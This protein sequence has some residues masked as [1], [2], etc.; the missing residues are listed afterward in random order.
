MG[1]GGRRR[2]GELL[3]DRTSL[4]S[5]QLARALR[6]QAELGQR[7]G[8]ILLGRGDIAESDLASVLAEQFDLPQ[9]TEEDFAAAVALDGQV[10]VDFMQ[11]AECVPLSLTDDVV[12]VAV[13]DPSDRFL[14]DAIE[15][16]TGRAVERRIGTRSNI[17]G[18]L[19]RLYGAHSTIDELA[20]DTGE[21]GSRDHAADLHALTEKS[22]QAPVVRVVDEIISKALALRAS[23]VHIEP[24]R[25]TL[26]LRYRIDGVLR[27]MQAPPAQS[28]AAIVSRIKVLANLDIA[29]QRLPQDGRMHHRIDGRDIDIRVSAVPTY[30]G[31]SVVL[32]LL[33][34]ARAPLAFDALGFSAAAA[35]AVETMVSRPHGMVLCAGPTGSG[36]TT[37]LYAALQQVNSPD[38][39]L[40]TVEDPVEYQLDGI[41][42]MQ[43][44]PQLGL[45]FSRAL[46]SMLCQDPDVIMVG[47][48]RDLETASI[49]VQAALTGHKVFSSVHT[50]DAAST[51]TRL[52]DMGVEQYLL[53]S[54]LDAV[55]AQRLVKVLCADCKQAYS[56]PP[57]IRS[58]LSEVVP[59]SGS[60][61]L[62]RAAGCKA[63]GHTGFRGRTCILELMLVDEAIRAKILERADAGA[64]RNTA[65]EQGMVTLY[66]DGIG[67]AL[68]GVTTVEE[69]LRV[70]ES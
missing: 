62:Y 47:E 32:R 27:D 56:P 34:K 50:N 11:R 60:V 52:V 25:S 54:T 28:T 35:P 42:Q 13:T 8:A 64:I 4:D 68:G 41:N 65:I 29:E 10:A 46:R 7:I 57:A 39:K 67:K 14:V 21:V 3:I 19:Q 49:A 51:V 6:L 61:Q 70:T 66:Q 33:D 31:E 24:F 17:L 5:E 15:L 26:K 36:K 9:A 37:T 18:T 53:A 55:L 40:L 12:T 16:A 48:M 45:T 30:F 43:V 22:A 44:R 69:V 59:I 2:I 1:T 20:A 23:D 38:R 63:C 58:E